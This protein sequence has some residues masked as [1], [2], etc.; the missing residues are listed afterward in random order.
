VKSRIQTSRM[1][2]MNS[3][4][5]GSSPASSAKVGRSHR[6]MTLSWRGEDAR[7]RRRPENP[8][9]R[10]GRC[11]SNRRW[12]PARPARSGCGR[13]R[14]RRCWAGAVPPRPRPSGPAGRQAGRGG[15]TAWA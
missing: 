3:T 12:P 6:T 11:G 15:E 10:G 5:S 14:V 1:G 9:Y 4:S 2:S 7:W 8:G 13:E